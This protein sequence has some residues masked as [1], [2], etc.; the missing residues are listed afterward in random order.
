MNLPAIFSP[1]NHRGWIYSIQ[2]QQQKKIVP[3]ISDAFPVN[4]APYAFAP[5]EVS[6]SGIV[7]H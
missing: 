2:Q 4:K 3:N 5:W 6:G 7:L 1:H